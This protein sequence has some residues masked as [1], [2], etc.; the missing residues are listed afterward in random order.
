MSKQTYYSDTT[1]TCPE[2]FGEIPLIVDIKEMTHKN[3][4]PCTALWTGRHLQ[5]SLDSI[6][7]HSETG[8]VQHHSSD[9]FLF[10]T[11]G[12]GLAIMGERNI[13]LDYQCQVHEN[14]SIL[15]PCK[16]WLN[17]I[18]TGDTPL[19]LYSIRSPM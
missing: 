1:H 9:Q 3:N 14:S 8:P 10:I 16:I 7:P 11:Q 12:T 4:H 17:L 19:Q 13:C 15:V 6:P 18:N 2:D 5:L